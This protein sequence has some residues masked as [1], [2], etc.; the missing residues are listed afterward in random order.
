MPLH[1]AAH[2]ADYT[3]ARWGILTLCRSALF[4]SLLCEQPNPQQL[5]LSALLRS[6][7]SSSSSFPRLAAHPSPAIPPPSQT[8]PGAVLSSELIVLWR[9]HLLLGHCV[10]CWAREEV[11]GPWKSHRR[12]CMTRAGAHGRDFHNEA[13]FF[14]FLEEGLG[15][16]QSL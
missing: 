12:H 1:N 11:V 8:P 14:F 4:L 2:R 13:F 15:N 16:S 5:V 7:F 6:Q 10:S 3:L 9:P